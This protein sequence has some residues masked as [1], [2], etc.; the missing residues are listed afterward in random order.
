MKVDGHAKGRSCQCRLTA[1]HAGPYDRYARYVSFHGLHSST[2]PTGVYYGLMAMLASTARVLIGIYLLAIAAAAMAQVPNSSSRAV[3]LGTA[4]NVS[5]NSQGSGGDRSAGLVETASETSR[6]GAA[7]ASASGA[8]GNEPM[9]LDLTVFDDG[10]A[11]GRLLLPRRGTVVAGSGTV[12]QGSEL[13]LLFNEGD[14]GSHAWEAELAHATMTSDD[15]DLR[16]ALAERRPLVASFS[17]RRDMGFGAEG[18]AIKG[19]LAFTSEPNIVINADLRRFAEYSTWDFSQ[20]RVHASFTSPHLPQ[21]AAPL[22]DLLEERGRRQLDSFVAEGRRYAAEGVLGWAWEQEEY[23]T[24]EGLAGSYLS[25]LNN[26]YSYTGGA[27]PNTFYESFLFEV[28]PSGVNELGIGDLFRQDSSWLPRLTPLILS[29]L[30]AQGAAWVTQGQV[31][32]LTT[33]DLATFTLGPTG[34][35]FHFAPYAMGPYV[36]GSF[37]VTLDYGQLVGLAPAG[38]ALEQFA[39]GIPFR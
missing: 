4:L 28:R 25:M 12:R 10:F 18:R 15:P 31:Q 2:V 1:C 16:A 20:G 29:D 22:N 5:T 7:T 39:R 6:A 8:G 33:T 37:T 21:E 27:H 3:Y 35:T 23:V 30:E 13:R 17:G 11:Y 9:I 32:E 36:Q 19:A 26:I 24:L 14:P 34:L 38:G